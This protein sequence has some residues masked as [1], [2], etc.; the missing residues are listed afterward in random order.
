MND[1]TPDDVRGLGR[2]FAQGGERYERLRPDYPPAALEWL[3]GAVPLGGRIA[4]VGSGTGKLAAALADR[5]FRVVA[6]DP[7]EDMSAQLRRRRSDVDI[8]VGTGEHT[9]L[10]D[11]SVD[12]VTFAQS[13]HWVEPEAGTA[14]LA[15]ILVAGGSVAMVGNFLD[16]RVD[17]VRDLAAA[18]HSASTAEAVDLTRQRPEL[19]PR[20]GSLESTTIDWVAPLSRTDLVD[21]VTTRSYYLTATP[22]AQAEIRSRVEQ[23]VEVT[24]PDAATIDL[25]YRTHGYR[26]G[27][28][29]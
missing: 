16:V 21:L 28:L 9:G 5:G 20:F 25:P 12:L 10:G 15:R 26:A 7:S 23:L 3:V 8:R 27:L 2:A 6:V 17:W 29:D 19:G 11:R 14:E 1:S 4:D 18:W 22:A 24:F 13:W